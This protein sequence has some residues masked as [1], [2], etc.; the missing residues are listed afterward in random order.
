MKEIYSN[1]LMEV[2]EFQRDNVV[3][4]SDGDGYDPDND[5]TEILRF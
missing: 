1:P 4:T 2:F 3:V 5:G